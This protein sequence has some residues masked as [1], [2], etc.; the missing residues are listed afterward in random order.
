MPHQVSI[1]SRRG[2]LILCLLL[3]PWGRAVA[4]DELPD[5]SPFE[6][7]SG[8]GAVGLWGDYFYRLSFDADFR[9]GRESNGIQPGDDVHIVTSLVYPV[10]NL[11]PAGLPTHRLV[12][13][14]SLLG[15]CF[16]MR[17]R[18]LL[19]RAPDGG[20]LEDCADVGIQILD[21]QQRILFDGDFDHI[22]R[23]V[24][25]ELIP[26]GR[27]GRWKLRSV[28]AFADPGFPFPVAGFGSG[29]SA[30]PPPGVTLVVGDD[31]LLSPF[32]TVS[33]RTLAP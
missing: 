20:A 1:W 4:Q 7:I 27:K 16:E 25:V 3:L 29:Q 8:D 33:F 5:F 30:G 2:T 12:V 15:Q 22:L 32:E 19:F 14:L 13:R 9:L 17:G 26:V 10:M 11:Q 24:T 28:A 31:G 6:S 21:G 18:S 23:T